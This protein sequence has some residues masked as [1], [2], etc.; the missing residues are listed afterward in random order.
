MNHAHLRYVSA[1]YSNLINDFTAIDEELVTSP[2]LSNSDIAKEVGD[3][4]QTAA[5]EEVQDDEDEEEDADN[6]AVLPSTNDAAT[7]VQVLQRFFEVSNFPNAEGTLK[8]LNKTDAV[9]NNI[10]IE[11]TVQK[12]VTDFFEPCNSK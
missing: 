2:I 8:I 5:N 11:R 9:V 1:N 7:A 6:I 12:H 4:R 3:A 10:W